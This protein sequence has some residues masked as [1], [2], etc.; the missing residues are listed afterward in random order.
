MGP[1]ADFAPRP[2]PRGGNFCDVLVIFVQIHTDRAAT[3]RESAFMLLLS[4]TRAGLAACMGAAGP[5][6][7]GAAVGSSRGAGR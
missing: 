6:E 1:A 3:R 7:Q 5:L 2:P 4:S